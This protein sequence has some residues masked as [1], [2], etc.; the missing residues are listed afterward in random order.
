[1]K[2]KTIAIIFIVVLLTQGCARDLLKIKDLVPVPRE[3][4]TKRLA[5][6]YENYF[7]QLNQDKEFFQYYHKRASRVRINARWADYVNDFPCSCKDILETGPVLPED[8][9][10]SVF[11]KNRPVFP[12]TSLN[13]V[14]SNCDRA[15]QKAPELLE[16]YSVA[17]KA[18]RSSLAQ[19]KLR[20]EAIAIEKAKDSLAKETHVNHDLYYGYLNKL[21]GVFKS[22]LIRAR[23]RELHPYDASL[24]YRSLENEY[25]SKN[26]IY[27]SLQNLWATKEG[28]DHM[29]E[30][31]TLLDSGFKVSIKRVNGV[32]VP[33][34]V[35][36]R[37]WFKE[38]LIEYFKQ[39]GFSV[40][41]ALSVLN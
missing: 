34:M 16:N 26:K 17:I 21:D 41:E 9:N 31:I 39:E 40:Y 28:R 11:P 1:M 12:K 19:V 36:T 24:A 10:R 22:D 2:R 33:S 7:T 15:L 18:I 32:A 13:R 20:K 8:F 29:R 5:L 37:I 35:F 30:I 27:A 38:S 3:R 14:M 25:R 23:S 6:I 4:A